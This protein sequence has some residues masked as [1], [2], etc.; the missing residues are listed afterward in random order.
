MF[1]TGKYYYPSAS[2]LKI[3]IGENNFVTKVRYIVVTVCQFHPGLIFAGKAGG[4]KRATLGWAPQ[5]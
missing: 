5:L 4:P 1:Q 2:T 3:L